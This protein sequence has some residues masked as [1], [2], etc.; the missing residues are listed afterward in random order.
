[1]ELVQ[2]EETEKSER[3]EVKFSEK[4][5][6]GEIVEKVARYICFPEH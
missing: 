2:M 1:M 5:M 3:E 6:P 4:V